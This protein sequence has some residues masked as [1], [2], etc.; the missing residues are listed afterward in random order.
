M[1]FDLKNCFTGKVQFAAEIECP[2]DTPISWKLRLAVLLAIKNKVNLSGA[3]LRGVDLSGVD[4]RGANLRGVNLRGADLSNANLSG[5][6]LVVLMTNNWTIYVQP[7][8][9]RIGC[10]YHTAAEWF[11][12]DDA[13][14]AKMSPRALDWWKVWKPVVLASHAAIMTL[15]LNAKGVK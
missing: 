3:D 12:F 15:K 11:G 6:N 7:D 4:L 13:T 2:E 10:Q 1:I 8:H 9:I 5:A 14:I